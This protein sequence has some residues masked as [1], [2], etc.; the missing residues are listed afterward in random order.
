MKKVFMKTEKP[1]HV[2]MS[3]TLVGVPTDKSLKQRCIV[4][5]KVV[6]QVIKNFL[7]WRPIMIFYD[8]M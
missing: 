4:L 1:G 7:Y 3:A 2:L 8:V 6:N 5:G